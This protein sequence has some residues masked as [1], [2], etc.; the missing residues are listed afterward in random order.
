MKK[1][2]TIA[3]LA[4]TSAVLVL[5]LSSCEVKPAD[6]S[7]NPCFWAKHVKDSVINAETNATL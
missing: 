6:T 7:N 5:A 3:L 1:K 2:L 4:M